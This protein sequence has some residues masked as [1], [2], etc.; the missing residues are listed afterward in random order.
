MFGIGM[1]KR[2]K[3][4]NIGSLG[5]MPR[6]TWM[7]LPRVVMFTTAGPCCCT[8][9]AKSG[10]IIRPC[11]AGVA[12]TGGVAAEACGTAPLA[13]EVWGWQAVKTSSAET[14]ARLRRTKG[15]WSMDSTRFMD[16][17]S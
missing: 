13:E 7:R 1:P 4:S 5:D 11:T 8:S 3:N 14:A 12:A 2:R 16:P 6:P 9:D 15:R 10:S 17:V